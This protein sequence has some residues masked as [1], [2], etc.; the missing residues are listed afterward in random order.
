MQTKQFKGLKWTHIS[1]PDRKTLEQVGL[2]Y[3]F[4]KL[5][6]DDCLSDSQ[7]S[8]L[9]V[10]DDYI[11][12]ILHF[13][14][15][16]ENKDYIK[17]GEV[18]IFLGKDYLITVS[19]AG[20]KIIDKIFTGSK[21]EEFMKSGSAFLLYKFIKKIFDDT[22]PLID[23][24]TSRLPSLEKAVFRNQTFKTSNLKEIL[25]LKKDV[26][27]FRRLIHPQ[28]DIIAELELIKNDFLTEKSTV[29]FD[30][31]LDEL[32]KIGS[33]LMAIKEV[34]ETLQDINE[35]IISRNTN[36]I[37]RTLTVVSIILM[38]LTLLSGIYGMNIHGLPFADNPY[39]FFIVTGVM[40][41]IALLMITYFKFRDWI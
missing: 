8:K 10:Y 18:G 14:Y 23:H 7:R 37:I 32:H 15:K 12:L 9:D 6:L 29:Y 25:S 11:F 38:P 3:G 16:K 41:L 4:H 34:V 26:I 19:R 40:L 31:I 20:T 39:A 22:F 27:N 35:S 1:S 28:V 13:P 36:N 24:I 17:I 5:D 30:D 2:D 33:D 21:E